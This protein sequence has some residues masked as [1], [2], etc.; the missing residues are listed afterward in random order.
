[1]LN[2]LQSTGEYL[3]KHGHEAKALSTYERRHFESAISTLVSNTTRLVNDPNVP[4]FDRM[5]IDK[6]LKAHVIPAFQADHKM[7]HHVK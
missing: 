6:A 4:Q 7:A 3:G 2:L 1:M 5:A